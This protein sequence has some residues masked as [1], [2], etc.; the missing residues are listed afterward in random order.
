MK[1]TVLF[2]LGNTLAHYFERHEFPN[3]LKQ[4][5]SEV[6]N[7]LHQSDLLR[8]SP[9]NMWRRVAEEDYESKD[10]R[11]RPLEARLARIF[12]LDDSVPSS[13]VI[14]AMCRRFMKPIFARGYCYEDTIPTLKEL[15]PNRFK[16]AIVS[17]TTWGSS[18]YLWREELE[19]LGLSKYLDAFVFCRNA[20]WRKPAK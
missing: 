7:Y 4:A 8:I 17:N 14:K 10:Y 12:Q 9:E 3:I 20:G 1:N 19:R 15:K 5:I 13:S 18:A 6:Q 2:D 11:V 16:T